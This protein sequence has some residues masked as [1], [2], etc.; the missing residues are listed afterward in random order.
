MLWKSMVGSLICALCLTVAQPAS[1]SPGIV[2]SPAH[3][4]SA[5]SVRVTVS[6][7][8]GSRCWAISQP[9]CTPVLLD[10]LATIV[11]LNYCS[12]DPICACN[13]FPFTYQRTCNFGVLPAGTYIAV[14]TELHINPY[15][16]LHTFTQTLGFTV[17]DGTSVAT[18]R[19]TCGALKTI[20][21]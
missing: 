6:N 7:D 20:Y 16:P 13:D 17:V 1:A 2:I 19:R 21:R 8:F 18:L 3:P 14:F 12:G 5:D 11:T 4:T 15:D 10:T 9:S